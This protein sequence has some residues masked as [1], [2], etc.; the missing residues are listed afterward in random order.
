MYRQVQN[1]VHQEG[2]PST[3]TSDAVLASLSRLTLPRHRLHT[4]PT[5]SSLSPHRNNPLSR[6]PHAAALQT[7]CRLHAATTS[8]PRRPNAA[9]TATP[10]PSPHRAIIHCHC[11]VALQYRQGP[12]TACKLYTFFREKVEYNTL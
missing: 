9:A 2:L 12:N 1:Q 11:R 10:T 7:Q 6:H 8:P 5:L 4:A 3:L